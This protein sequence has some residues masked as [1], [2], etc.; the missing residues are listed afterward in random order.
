MTIDAA[1]ITGQCRWRPEG[2]WDL[3]RP[4]LPLDPLLTDSDLLCAIG[5]MVH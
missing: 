2:R 4:P 5:A 3:R 1:I